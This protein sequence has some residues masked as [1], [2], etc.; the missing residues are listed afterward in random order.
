MARMKIHATLDDLEKL[1]KKDMEEILEYPTFLESPTIRLF[2]TKYLDLK[3]QYNSLINIY[4]DQHPK[5]VQIK[6]EMESIRNHIGD[7]VKN[8][9]SGMQKEYKS[10]KKKY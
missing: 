10:N 9:K 1:S 8:I 7:E 5:I 2:R 6:S 3:T 4:K